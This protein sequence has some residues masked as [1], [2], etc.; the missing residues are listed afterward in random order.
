[1]AKTDT[2]PLL[3]PHLTGNRSPFEDR[4]GRWFAESPV[5][6]H[7]AD[8]F[9]YLSA[10][11][12]EGNVEAHSPYRRYGCHGMAK[13]PSNRLIQG[14]ITS[15]ADATRAAS[16][17]SR[18]AQETRLGAGTPRVIP[19]YAALSS[20]FAPSITSTAVL[21]SDTSDTSRKNP[22]YGASSL[23]EAASGADRP[24]SATRDR[25]LARM[26]RNNASA[27]R[28]GN[29]AHNPSVIFLNCELR[30]DHSG[31]LRRSRGTPA[32]PIPIVV[33]APKAIKSGCGSSHHHPHPL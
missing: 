8:A 21:L 19:G 25:A 29:N 7:I 18:A 33:V 24:I 16:P 32:K 15:R 12:E 10:R 6:Q 30:P 2:V 23:Q 14:R 9:Q 17:A 27:S 28:F 11:I 1:M 26:H 4:H 22:P 31:Q 13:A 5:W 3:E 20:S